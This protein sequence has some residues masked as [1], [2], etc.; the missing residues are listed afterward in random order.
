MGTTGILKCMLR[1]KENDRALR[2][3]LNQIINYGFFLHKFTIFNS[4]YKFKEILFKIK[5][6]LNKYGFHHIKCKISHKMAWQK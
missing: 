1:A 3:I 4:P 2:K 6:P 5:I